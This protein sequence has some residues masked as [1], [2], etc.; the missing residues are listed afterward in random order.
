MP[1]DLTIFGAK[2]LV[3]IEV[4]AGV[5]LLVALLYRRPSPTIVRWTFATAVGLVVAYIAAKIGGAVYNDPRPFVVDHFRPLIAHAADNGFPSDHALLAAAVVAAVAL[6]R[7][8]WC[9][10]L[11]PVAILVEWARVGSGVHHPVDVLGS[12]VCVAIGVLVAILV[13][14]PLTRLT[15]PHIP[16]RLLDLVAAREDRTAR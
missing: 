15:L 1:A 16:A 4:A 8:L 11:V 10:L 9:F 12:D 14:P 5:V 13:A 3:F 7:V 2:Y 6:A